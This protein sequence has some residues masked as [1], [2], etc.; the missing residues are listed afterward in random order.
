MVLS[1][2][3]RR[4]SQAAAAD[5][6]AP[7]TAS[8]G[9][10]A[11]TRGRALRAAHGAGEG[12]GGGHASAGRGAKGWVRVRSNV[13]AARAARVP[14][15]QPAAS[16]TG[17]PPQRPHGSHEPRTMKLERLMGEKFPVRGRPPA[18]GASS[19]QGSDAARSPAELLQPQP[20][21]AR[22]RLARRAVRSLVRATAFR[23][24]PSDAIQELVRVGEAQAVSGCVY[25]M[26]RLRVIA[27]SGHAPLR[28]MDC[29]RI[30]SFRRRM[31]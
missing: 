22:A 4:A 19:V 21:G 3:M 26:V 2:R 29:V 27:C 10:A 16:T 28:L 15:S 30:G 24:V 31:Q 17:P 23:D 20:A 7:A 12:Q 9:A 1:R 25:R 14:A 13:I 11:V 8:A 5:P 6:G 18:G